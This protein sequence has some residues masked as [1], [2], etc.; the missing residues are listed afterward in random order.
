MFIENCSKIAVVEVA[1]VMGFTPSDKYRQP[2]VRVKTKMMKVL[3][4]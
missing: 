3:G 4:Y 2:N 1:S